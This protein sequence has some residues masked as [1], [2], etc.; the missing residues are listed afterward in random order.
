MCDYG[1]VYSVERFVRTVPAG[2]FSERYVDLDFTLG[3]CREC[4]NFNCN[5]ACPEFDEDVS[6][7]WTE[8]D[9]VELVAL[10]LSFDD[11]FCRE[12]HSSEEV[13]DIINGTLVKEK[14]N[15]MSYLCQGEEA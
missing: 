2:V 8:Y 5:W 10:K 15:I 9:S 6:R 1:D 13:A 7:Y 3:F 11:D 14:D 12:T 4:P